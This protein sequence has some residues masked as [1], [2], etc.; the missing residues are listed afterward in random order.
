MI[1]D[2][3]CTQDDAKK[4]CEKF[5]VQGYPTLK[6]F[7]PTTPS[8]GEK[9][10]EGRDYKTMQK[11]VKKKS[12]KPCVP[13]TLENCDK[14]DKAFI[15]EIKDYDEAKLKEEREKLEKEIGELQA[16]Q[17]AAADLF[18]EQKEVAIATMKKAEDLKTKLSKLQSK[19]GY[20][21][22]ILKAKAEPKKEEL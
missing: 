4:V 1:V 19:E 8:D 17:Q 5:G 7:G 3:D 21:L 16:E 14:K 11:F 2:V 15:E 20:K 18:E 10:E 22:F 12:K 13:D 6:Y 9:Y